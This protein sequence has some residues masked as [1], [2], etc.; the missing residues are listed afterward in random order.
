VGT[1][2]GQTVNQVILISGVLIFT[3]T[4]IIAWGCGQ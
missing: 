1:L 4:R 2:L 3:H